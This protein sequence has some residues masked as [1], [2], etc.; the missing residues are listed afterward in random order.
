MAVISIAGLNF[1][2]LDQCDL[3]GEFMFDPHQDKLPWQ[4]HEANP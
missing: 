3:A 4:I 2:W 1:L